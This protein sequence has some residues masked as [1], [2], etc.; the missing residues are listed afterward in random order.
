[1]DSARL[2]CFFCAST[3]LGSLQV[4]EFWECGGGSA[5]TAPAGIPLLEKGEKQQQKNPE[6]QRNS[7]E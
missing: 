1:M 3:G 4:W 2:G 6:E 7:T 5:P